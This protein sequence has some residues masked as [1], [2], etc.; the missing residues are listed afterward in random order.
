M[1]KRFPEEFKGDALAIAR[2]RT[3]PIEE[4]AAD[5]KHLDL[6]AAPMDPPGRHRRRHQ[7]RPDERRAGRDRGAA[8]QDPSPR[9]GERDPAASSR[10][11]RPTS[12]PKM[13]FPVVLDLAADDFPVTV[14]CGVLA[15]SI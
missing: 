1:P 10:L 2:R 5:F 15:F 3:V 8:A 4:V 6:D 7:G 14:T 13:R 9:D 11:L 12:A